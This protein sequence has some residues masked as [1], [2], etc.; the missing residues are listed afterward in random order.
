MSA[1]LRFPPVIKNALLAKEQTLSHAKTMSGFLDDLGTSLWEVVDG[2]A[3]AVG[4]AMTSVVNAV[5]QMG[6]TIALVIRAAIGDVKWSEVLHSLGEVFQDVGNVL[7]VINPIRLYTNFL[8]EA[9]LTSHAFNELDKFSGGMISTGVNVSD[10][11]WRSIRGDPVSKYELLQDA[12]FIIQVAAI[13]FTGP[14]G[15]GIM[16]GTM[17]GRQVC[18]KQTEARDACMVAFQI[19]GAA[20]GTWASAASGLTWGTA[21][22][23]ADESTLSAA[24]EE[25]WLAGDDAYQAFLQRQAEQ[26]ALQ[27]TT[28]FL[29]HLSAAAE[30]Y[31]L[32]Q[33]IGVAT[34]QL[35]NLCDKQ[36][37]AGGKECDILAQVAG[38]YVRNEMTNNIPFEEFLAQEVARVGAEELMLQWFPPSSPEHQA[39]KRAWQIKRTTYEVP[40]YVVQEGGGIGAFL[41]L[42]AGGAMVL[43]G[44]S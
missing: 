29:P 27:Q 25:A 7:V 11:V 2:M 10:V 18:S 21:A 28:E 8:K 36:G 16:V 17:V 43:M 41:L 15:I 26:V 9:P 19:A 4:A 32:S 37:W 34:Q 33:G 20:A 3:D 22:E 39:I 6:E 31:L 35:S 40:Q 1:A 30:N 42:A 13:V 38:N 24:E 5:K 44:A 14:V 12:I 23:I